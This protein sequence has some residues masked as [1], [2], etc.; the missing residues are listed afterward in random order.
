MAKALGKES[1]PF[2]KQFAPA[3]G[4]SIIHIRISEP[5]STPSREIP[6]AMA[7]LRLWNLRARLVSMTERRTEPTT[8]SSIITEGWGTDPVMGASTGPTIT[9]RI[10]SSSFSP[11]FLCP[12]YKFG[13]QGTTGIAYDP[14]N[15]SLWISS[16]SSWI[17]D[18][19]LDGVL[20]AAF[21]SD[22]SR[23]GYW[24]NVALG[25]DPADHTLWIANEGTNVL[26]QYSLDG[27]TFGQLLQM[28]TPDGLPGVGDSG[29]FQVLVRTDFTPPV[30][31]ASASPGPNANGW[32]NTNVTVTLNATD[33]PGGSGVKQIQFA[34]ARPPL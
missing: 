20:L 31:T 12:E 26:R 11:R 10:R 27:V 9:G 1:L 28:G 24:A 2:R 4:T 25:L 22:P 14:T 17:A 34:L 30:T 5:A 7:T 21:D 23:N 32:N 33:N 8:I 29:E 3:P 15:N 13:C 18:Y 19:S 6:P 16:R